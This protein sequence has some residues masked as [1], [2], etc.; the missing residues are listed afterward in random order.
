MKAHYIIEFLD[1]SSRL[2]TAAKDGMED[3]LLTGGLS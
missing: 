2:F 3:P 1:R